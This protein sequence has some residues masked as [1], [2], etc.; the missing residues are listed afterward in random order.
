MVLPYS[1]RVTILVNIARCL[2]IAAKRLPTGYVG[3]LHYS[4][5]LLM[6]LSALTSREAGDRTGGDPAFKCFIMHGKG[7]RQGCQ[8]LR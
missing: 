7:K 6:A 1:S 5:M 4:P 8:L 3:S 2:A